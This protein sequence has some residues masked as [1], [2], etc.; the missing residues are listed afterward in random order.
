MKQ[1]PAWIHALAAAA[2]AIVAV[3]TF[4]LTRAH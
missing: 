2:S 3:A 4:F 1:I